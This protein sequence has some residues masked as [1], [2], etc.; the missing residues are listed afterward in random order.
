MTIYIYVYMI[1]YVYIYLYLYMCVNNY[2]FPSPWGTCV[3]GASEEV[4]WLDCRSAQVRL[5]VSM[6][7]GDVVV[8][9]ENDT[10]ILFRKNSVL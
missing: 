1:I 9:R 4:F 8:E 3:E 6:A 7:P 10:L 2:W 5:P